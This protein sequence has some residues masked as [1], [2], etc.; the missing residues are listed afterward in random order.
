ME[1]EEKKVELKCKQCECL[2]N[3]DNK[4]IKYNK[5]NPRIIAFKWKIEYCNDC[6]KQKVNKS[7]KRL[8]EIIK[9]LEKS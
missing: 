8:P 6:Y 4:Y 9:I 5:K 7:L 2:F 1:A 3:R